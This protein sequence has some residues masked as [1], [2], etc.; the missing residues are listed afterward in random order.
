MRWRRPLLACAVAVAVLDLAAATEGPDTLQSLIGDAAC[1]ADTQCATLGV[2]AKA[3]GGPSSY[4]AW[5]S[6][7][8]DAQRL[9]A[10][11]GRESEAQRRRMETRGEM[12]DCA[13][14]A[15]PGAYC[16]VAQVGS[17]GLGVCRL[18]SGGRS[19]TPAIR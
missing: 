7:R 12:S 3:C 11:A 16:D 10:L 1:R 2:G 4:V 8:T 13:L 6:L 14:V 5:S 17:S 9:R 15:D 18:R 19:Q